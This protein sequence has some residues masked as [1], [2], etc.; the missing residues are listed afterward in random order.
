VLSLE[1][2]TFPFAGLQVHGPCQIQPV[3]WGHVPEWRK[4]F[5]RVHGV[6]LK[7]ENWKAETYGHGLRIKQK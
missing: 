4:F 3:G 2:G 1:G 6:K 5:R 7:A